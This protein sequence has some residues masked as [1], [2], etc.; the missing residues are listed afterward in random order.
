MSGIFQAAERAENDISTIDDVL[1]HLGEIADLL[2]KSKTRTAEGLCVIR[3]MIDTA[4]AEK[5]ELEAVI[6]KANTEERR[7]EERGY[8]R[9]VL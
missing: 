1:Y 3:D 8:W 7:A 2:D 6:E 4:K 5:R 9:D